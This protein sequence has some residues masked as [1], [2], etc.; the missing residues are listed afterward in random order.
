MTRQTVCEAAGAERGGGLL[1]LAVDLLE[2]GC[3]VRTTKGR[4]MKTSAMT[5]PSGV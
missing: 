2:T 1:D 4:P 3:T 5:M